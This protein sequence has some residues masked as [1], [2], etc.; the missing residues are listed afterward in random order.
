[1]I[2]CLVFMVKLIIGNWFLIP[3]QLYFESF[4]ESSACKGLEW[5]V[6]Q[7]VQ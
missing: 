6:F 2:S 1:M 5:M 7:L 3:K 4:K